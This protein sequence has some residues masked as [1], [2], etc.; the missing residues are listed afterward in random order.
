MGEH[1]RYHRWAERT[2][3]L[4]GVLTAAALLPGILVPGILA[5]VALWR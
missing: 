5:L 3:V 2:L 4:G 1:L